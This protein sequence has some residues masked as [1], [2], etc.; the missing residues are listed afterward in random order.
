MTEKIL[1]VHMRERPVEP[2]VTA[3]WLAERTTSFSGAEIEALCRRAMM[4]ALAERIEV[5]P[6]APDIDDFAIRRNHLLEAIEE[7]FEQAGRKQN[8]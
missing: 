2:G 6:E 3:A 4:T 5:S 7:L 1:Q 8:A